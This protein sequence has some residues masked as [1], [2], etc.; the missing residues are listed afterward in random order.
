MKKCRF[1]KKNNVFPSPLDSTCCDACH[2]RNNKI[3][4]ALQQ[5]SET[6]AG[7]LGALVSHVEHHYDMM[8]K[9]YL[10][11]GACLTH[12]TILEIGKTLKVVRE[13]LEI[14]ETSL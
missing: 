3:H 14:A 10:A 8:G 7:C 11:K 5:S 4:Q 12:P 13:A 9:K 6:L 2:D 1:C